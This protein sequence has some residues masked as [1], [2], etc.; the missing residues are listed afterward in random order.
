M[1][2]SNRAFSELAP[3]IRQSFEVWAAR[4][5]GMVGRLLLLLLEEAALSGE[6]AKPQEEEQHFE[7]YNLVLKEVGSLIIM[8]VNQN[9]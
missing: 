9:F 2:L 5:L 1:Q 4:K 7:A 6:S 8:Y 3:R